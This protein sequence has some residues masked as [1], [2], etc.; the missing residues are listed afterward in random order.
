[1]RVPVLFNFQAL[2]RPSTEGS[3]RVGQ[4]GRPDGRELNR[5]G[6]ARSGT[7]RADLLVG[8]IGIG[9]IGVRDPQ[10]PSHTD[11][12]ASWLQGVA[13]RKKWGGPEEREWVPTS[14]TPR[15]LFAK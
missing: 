1:M 13:G 10:T 15:H 3:W 12:E 9:Q 8:Q 4:G 6:H 2:S 7:D 5:E 11:L 14:R